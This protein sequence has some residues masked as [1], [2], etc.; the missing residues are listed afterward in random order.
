MLRRHSLDTYVAH[1]KSDK[2]RADGECSQQEHG[3]R[4]VNN[5]DAGEAPHEL[6]RHLGYDEA[7]SHQDDKADHECTIL[8]GAFEPRA[9]LAHNGGPEE[10]KPKDE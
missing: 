10:R 7:H 3:V 5:R 8:A 4:I 6:P 9:Q 2:D 1:R